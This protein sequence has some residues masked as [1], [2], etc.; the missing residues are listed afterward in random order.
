MT[1]VKDIFDFLCEMAPLRLAESYDNPGLLAGDAAKPVTRAAIAL[2]ITPEVCS[3]AADSGCE[4]IVSHHPVIF[5]PVSSVRKDG[6][7]AALWSLVNLGLSAIC[8]H[9]NLDAAPG[10]VNDTLAEV[11]GLEKTGPLLYGRR[12]NYKK[13][14]VF[15]PDEYAEE[16][17]AAMADAGA[18]RF[19][20]YDECAFAVKGEGCFRPLEGARPF[21]GKKGTLE[22]AGETK[23]EAVC[24]PEA[25]PAV[26]EAIRRA[27]P[28]E[29]PAYDIFDDEA[30]FTQYGIGMTA[31]LVKP[32]GPD[33]FARFV[34]RTLGTDGASVSKA[35]DK[36][37]KIAVCSGA[38]DDELTIAAREKGCDTILTGELKHSAKLL[39]LALGLN[40]VA[41]GHY[42][43]E[44]VVCPALLSR[45]GARFP[46]VAFT[47]AHTKAP[48]HFVG[49]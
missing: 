48:S 17:R 13:I 46:D 44:N 6:A 49:A 41:A 32:T 31:K 25:A 22:R 16:V 14:T 47:L 19:G 34:A 42:A 18:G 4:L 3:E 5:R 36:C 20:N 28:Y 11:L 2:D 37:E 24:S 27:H 39:A 9:T 43:T 33:D 35:G 23:I 10:G 12:E 45:L 40:V 26:V 21:I 30:L 8:M 29:E 1:T 38:W 15:V 7:E